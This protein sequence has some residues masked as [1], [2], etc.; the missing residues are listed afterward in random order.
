MAKGFE[1]QMLLIARLRDEHKIRVETLETS[2]RWFRKNHALTPVTTFSVDKDIA[3]SNLKTLWFNSRFYRMNM[4]WEN[5]NLRIRD[6]HLFNENFPSIYETQVATSNECS[7]FTLPFV[8]GYIWT[9]PNQMAGLRLKAIIDGK[10][11]ALEG[12]DPKFTKTGMSTLHISWPLKTIDGSF[13][14]D[15]TEQQVKMQLLTT[16]AISWFFDLNTAEKVKLPFDSITSK[17]ATCSFE[18]MKY[19]VMAEKGYFSKPDNGSV[20]RLSPEPNILIINFS[21]SSH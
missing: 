5:G 15:L 13:E 10:E 14:V 21:G 12:N 18:N 17:T 4:L 20:W 19:S 16:K 6:I 8:D 9:K 1:I 2:G 3:G 7:F 11:R